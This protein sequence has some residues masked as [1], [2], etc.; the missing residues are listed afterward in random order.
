MF[1]RLFEGVNLDNFTNLINNERT[2]LKRVFL[3]IAN[4]FPS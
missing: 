1:H 3:Q 4:F 2:A